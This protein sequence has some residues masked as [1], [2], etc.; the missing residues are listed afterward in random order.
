MCVCVCVCVCVCE[1]VTAG[2]DGEE[3]TFVFHQ[4]HECILASCLWN[5]DAL[6]YIVVCVTDCPVGWLASKVERLTLNVDQTL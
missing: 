4:F 1:T 3:H 2:G 5:V 6:C